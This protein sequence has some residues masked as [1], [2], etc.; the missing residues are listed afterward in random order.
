LA[1]V[2]SAVL[3]GKSE[4][5][6]SLEITLEIANVEKR[7]VGSQAHA[8]HLPSLRDQGSY[9][10]GQLDFPILGPW[11]FPQQSEDARAEDIPPGDRQPTH[12]LFWTRFFHHICELKNRADFLPRLR[13]SI[14]HH[15]GSGHLTQGD[16]GIGAALLKCLD[17][18]SQDVRLAME[19]NNHVSQCQSK[20]L[21]A[22]ERGCTPHGVAQAQLLVLAREKKLPARLTRGEM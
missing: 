7:F 5:A 21:I 17:H 19:A 3:V 9:G 20:R 22:D 2:G 18:A 4:L 12:G 13:D 8:N 6:E 11:G 15:I 16:Y 10:I 1:E 14:M